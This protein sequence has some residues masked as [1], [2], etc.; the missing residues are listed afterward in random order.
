M[1]GGIKAVKNKLTDLN[2]HLFEALE[3]LNDDEI[4]GDKLGEEI[5]RSKAITGVAREI[6][7]NGKLVLD[8]H[9]DFGGIKT[10]PDM[11]GVGQSSAPGLG[12]DK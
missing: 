10:A 2:N 9:R 4:T 6:I 3:R 8:A 12:R 11:L 5:Q 1:R 7:A